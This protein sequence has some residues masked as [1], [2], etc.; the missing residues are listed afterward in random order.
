MAGWA[1]GKAEGIVRYNKMSL[2]GLVCLGRRFNNS[3][4]PKDNGVSIGYEG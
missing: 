1:S 2:A 3:E 4:G